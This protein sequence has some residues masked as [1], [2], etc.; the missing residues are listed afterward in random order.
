MRATRM[1]CIGF[2]LVHGIA[3]TIVMGP[4]GKGARPVRLLFPP[5]FFDF[6]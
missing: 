2:F 5:A 1:G 4:I 6:R 3:G